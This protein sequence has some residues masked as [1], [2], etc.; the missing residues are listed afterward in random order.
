MTLDV[1]SSQKLTF[2]TDNNRIAFR[3]SMVKDQNGRLIIFYQKQLKTGK[4]TGGIATNPSGFN[5]S[6]TSGTGT[7]N[8]ISKSWTSDSVIAVPSLCQLVYVDPAAVGNGVGITSNLS[9]TFISTIIPIAFVFSGS[10]S[11]VRLLSIE[12]EGNYIYARRQKP[13][14]FGGWVWDNYEDILNSGESPSAYFNTLTNRIHLTYKRNSSVYQRIIQVGN[15]SNAWSLLPDYAETA[16]PTKIPDDILNECDIIPSGARLVSPIVSTFTQLYDFRTDNTNNDKLT[17]SGARLTA[18]TTQFGG[19]FSFTRA[20]GTKD[21][22]LNP[23]YIANLYLYLPIISLVSGTPITLLNN[24]FYEIYDTDNQTLLESVPYSANIGKWKN[25]DAYVGK[26]IFLGF[27]GQYSVYNDKS[28]LADISLSPADR[29][30]VDAFN[31][32]IQ[33]E[34]GNQKNVSVSDLIKEIIPSSL[35]LKAQ[36]DITFIQL[37][38]FETD[39]T[40]DSRGAVG[41]SGLP[42]KVSVS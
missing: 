12:N 38:D 20:S 37:Y 34:E 42:L 10:S 11:I 16:G 17:S 33:T 32:S 2:E 29:S 30:P 26:R 35:P 8:G 9:M 13:D 6:I 36:I 3:P 23:G 18:I 25:I 5:I 14:G 27:R 22:F 39:N 15:E 31:N 41:T 40:I 24:T 7:L 28:N 1:N 4:T 19:S 21:T